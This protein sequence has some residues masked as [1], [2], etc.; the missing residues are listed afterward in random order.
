[1]KSPRLSLRS[2]TSGDVP[3]LTTLNEQLILDEGHQ[4]PMNE[5]Q[6]AIRMNEWLEAEYEASVFQ[7]DDEI[8]GYAL[9]REESTVM[10]LRQFFIR[11]EF[12]R[13]GPGADRLQ[14]ANRYLAG[15]ETVR[16]PRCSVKQPGRYRILARHRL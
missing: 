6:L 2:A 3:L 13:Q 5:A 1:M 15:S 8:V 14:K 16:A 4:N 7:R 10:Y 11:S 9:Y 12:R